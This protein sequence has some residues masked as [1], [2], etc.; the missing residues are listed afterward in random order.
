MDKP[1]EKSEGKSSRLVDRFVTNWESS[2][3]QVQRGSQGENWWQ[4]PKA[5]EELQTT[6]AAEQLMFPKMH[7]VGLDHFMAI[8]REVETYK[9]FVADMKTINENYGDV[10]LSLTNYEKRFKLE[11]QRAPDKNLKAIWSNCSAFMRHQRITTSRLLRRRWQ[12]ALESPYRTDFVRSD[13]TSQTSPLYPHWDTIFSMAR[14][15]AKA[16]RV[17]ELDAR[18][19]IRLATILHFGL[20]LVRLRTIARLVILAYWCGS[21][22]KIDGTRLQSPIDKLC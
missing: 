22:G 6:P 5:Y 7:G 17:T 21:L 15:P 11:R 18:L 20:P 2:F 4:G 13:L 1:P 12:L 8:V 19:Q 10:R 9:K 3:L 14:Y 16:G